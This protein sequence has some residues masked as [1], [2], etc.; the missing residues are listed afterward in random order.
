MKEPKYY[1]LDVEKYLQETENKRIF[2]K[3]GR[4]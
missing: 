4:R 2:D 1:K 3:K